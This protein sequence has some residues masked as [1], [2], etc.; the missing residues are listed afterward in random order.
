MALIDK[1][2]LLGQIA[3]PIEQTLATRIIDEFVSIER[4]YI[5]RDWEPAELDGGQFAELTARIY[6]HQD[7]GVLNLSKSFDDCLKYIQDD[8]AT[9]RIVPRH[10]AMHVALALRLIYKIR[11]QR[12]AIH[13]SPNYSANEMDS[14][15][16]V[17]GAHWCFCE[18]LR[19]FWKGDRELVAKA[20]RELLQFDVPA[21]GKFGDRILVQRARL[22]V[23]PEVLVLLHYAGESG[24]SRAEVGKYAMHPAPT[25][26]R[27]LQRLSS[28]H[29][30][31]VI[32]LGGGNYRLTDIGS[33]R[34]REEFADFLLLED[35]K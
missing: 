13:I 12:G 3:P 32:Q 26:T 35:R 21:I 31:E 14:K 34:V 6:Y 19:K 22:P 27:S 7:S 17:D 4:R 29:R 16:V 25:L 5:L 33:K 1:V 11:S 20:V 28:P 10:D 24:Y 2:S 18:L 9:H 15:I 23:D 8:N 30:R